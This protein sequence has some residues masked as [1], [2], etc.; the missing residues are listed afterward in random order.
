V[1][2]RIRDW[3]IAVSIAA[4]L[5]ILVGGVYSGVTGW[6]GP[7]GLAAAATTGPGLPSPD[8]PAGRPS[9]TPSPGS[10]AQSAPV[11]TGEPAAPTAA[12]KAAQAK[13]AKATEQPKAKPKVKHPAKPGPGKDG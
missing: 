13:P 12:A 1:E 8:E 4:V 7:A 6:T 10:A 9:G 2:P 3:A 11:R 5:G